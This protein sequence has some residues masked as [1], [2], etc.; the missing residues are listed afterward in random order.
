MRTADECYRWYADF[1]DTKIRLD[2]LLLQLQIAANTKAD[3][4]KV[5]EL[6]AETVEKMYRDVYNKSE[7]NLRDLIKTKRLPS[8]NID[9]EVL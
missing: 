2:M 1:Q 4:T 3:F 6:L 9:L 7:G 5:T 8:K